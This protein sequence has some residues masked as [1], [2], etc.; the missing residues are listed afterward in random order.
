MSHVLRTVFLLF[1]LFFGMEAGAAAAPPWKLI[2][3]DAAAED[4]FGFSVDISGDTAI[5]GAP[6]DDD[7]G[8]DSGSA[9]VFRWN[10]SDWQ[11]EDKL[12]AHD[13]AAGDQFGATVAVDGD[14]AIVG[15]KFDDSS[16]GAAYVFVRSGSSW[17]LQQKLVAD[18]AA[19]GDLL[20]HDV[21]VDGD[22]AIVG[23]TSGDGNAPNS[24]SAY[25]FT[26]SGSVWTQQEEL[27]APDGGGGDDFGSSVAIDGDSA[28]VGAYLD[29][30][31]GSFSGSAYVFTRS[32][33]TWSFEQILVPL[34][35]AAGDLFGSA[36]DIEADTALISAMRDEDTAGTDQGSAY[37]F[38]RSGS[39]WLQDTK[40]LASDAV[41][42]QWFGRSA[43]LNEGVAVVGAY[44][45]D[46]DTGA[47]YVFVD[48]GSDWVEQLKIVAPDAAAGDLAG[49]IN[50]VAKSA[51]LLIVGAQRD[52]DD[53]TWSGSA[54]IFNNIPPTEH[55]LFMVLSNGNQSPPNNVPLGMP[56]TYS[57]QIDNLGGL[58]PP[59]PAGSD[60][61]V[62]TRFMIMVNGQSRPANG[63]AFSS[64]TCIVDP[65]D[66]EL[67][68]CPDLAMGASQVVDFTWLD[69]D[70]S[71]SDSGPD[72]GVRD[73]EFWGSW[74]FLAPNQAIGGESEPVLLGFE[75]FI[76]YETFQEFH[77]DL[78]FSGTFDAAA[79][80][81]T[82]GAVWAGDPALDTL[83][84]DSLGKLTG[85][86]VELETIGNLGISVS[87]DRTA[88]DYSAHVPVR[89]TLDLPE[90]GTVAAEEK[91]TV[92]TNWS[93]PNW[94]GGMTSGAWFTASRPNA[95]NIKFGLKSEM[96]FDLITTGCW[97]GDCDIGYLDVGDWFALEDGGTLQ[98]S[99][100]F[101]QLILGEGP[102]WAEP[103]M[104][105]VF[106]SGTVP[107][108]IE[109]FF[110]GS[111]IDIFV[112]GLIPD[113]LT[114]DV[115]RTIKGDFAGLSSIGFGT[116]FTNV[117]SVEKYSLTGLNKGQ[118]VSN[119][120]S[121]NAIDLTLDLSNIYP[122][123]MSFLCPCP[124]PL[125]NGTLADLAAIALAKTDPTGTRSKVL[126]TLYWIG[127]GLE[128]T[129]IEA[130]L[131][132]RFDAANRFQLTPRAPEI[133]LVNG[134]TAL[135]GWFRAGDDV[136]V[137]MPANPDNVSLEVRATPSFSSSLMVLSRDTE[138]N[139]QAWRLDLP[140]LPP[141]GPAAEI[142]SIIE[143]AVALSAD[144]QYADVETL[145]F[146]RRVAFPAPL[147]TPRS[148]VSGGGGLAFGAN[149]CWEPDDLPPGVESG[150]SFNSVDGCLVS[151][152]E[153][154]ANGEVALS[155]HGD[156]EISLTLQNSTLS[157]QGEMLAELVL[158]PNGDTSVQLKGETLQSG[159]NQVDFF[160]NDAISTG[161]HNRIIVDTFN[162]AF[163][164]N[165]ELRGLVSN[166]NQ[167][168]VIL[169]NGR[170]WIDATDME[171]DNLTVNNGEMTIQDST[172]ILRNL[173]VGG[174][175]D[176]AMRLT[177]DSLITTSSNVSFNSSNLEVG[178][179][180]LVNVSGLLNNLGVINLE[181][182]GW[183]TVL[184]GNDPLYPDRLGSSLESPGEVNIFGLDG[185]AEAYTALA[186]VP[187]PD[188]GPVPLFTDHVEG[189]RL[190]TGVLLL[191]N[192]EIEN[193]VIN[194]AG[195]AFLGLGGSIVDT[196]FNFSDQATA[197]FARE[198]VTLTQSTIAGTG[199]I[200]VET[201]GT[202][203][204]EEAVI[205]D[206]IN[207]PASL[208]LYNRG[209]LMV[210]NQADVI[211]NAR[212]VNEGTLEVSSAQQL[213][214]TQLG[215]NGGLLLVDGTLMMENPIEILSGEMDG[216][217][218]VQGD[219]IN[220]NGV[221]VANGLNITGGYSQRFGASF[222]LDFSTTPDPEIGV[223]EATLDGLLQLVL[224]DSYL[225]A[226]FLGA[227]YEFLTYTSRAGEFSDIVLMK[228]DGTLITD[229]SAEVIYD[230]N[231][232]TVSWA[233]DPPPE[234]TGP[235]PEVYGIFRNGFE[236]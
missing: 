179:G 166:E 149:N 48:A 201:T 146:S 165:S 218:S 25:V 2:A 92:S 160:F 59:L 71:F 145:E 70:P 6:F 208:F 121:E 189:S 35:G 233:Y 178:A 229:Y 52:S 216:T 93:T 65:V 133:R 101:L 37:I 88:V 175:A 118:S 54:H 131:K 135:T 95:V 137:E 227:S 180:S 156:T 215:H 107:K 97:A 15:A 154:T 85:F 29:G 235:A 223:D 225:Q 84:L 39:T 4:R 122:I 151:T 236:E 77:S 78:D 62:E 171:L 185:V 58:I 106:N 170:L 188:I 176:S 143:N 186:L 34:D 103:Y 104:Q 10:G 112:N 150:I 136:I 73:V 50:G 113:P 125:A 168:D 74:N 46:S 69:P 155:S 203:I 49:D 153:F 202:L 221:I 138:I 116:D 60:G 119:G 196:T 195:G 126:N 147:T 169:E 68:K 161:N 53:G 86:K 234:A 75:T 194:S 114:V 24:G 117:D 120:W 21:A 224:P 129:I 199:Q 174:S 23:A 7:G 83:G 228:T 19:V 40:L 115:L 232:A 205:G 67:W 167:S 82:V 123:A 98:Q 193:H 212:I 134:E 8:M 109:Q 231:A 26:R 163:I 11:E 96:D 32:G 152:R 81:G 157:G 198:P 66:P 20:G 79:T 63:G 5:V 226:P 206:L 181:L 159:L 1:C 87:V 64:S 127:D 191:G 172:A 99:F 200:E 130:E 190:N 18:D 197:V 148:T 128:Y 94:D 28:I 177:R 204:L 27:I 56:V 173:Q 80:E 44:R 89:V 14:T 207:E 90:D 9:Y 164:R 36:V 57:L 38:T 183:L 76:G 102:V 31:S 132:G 111:G 213:V 211:G 45:D 108:S 217:G 222:K 55:L 30:Y 13:A 182:G 51:D 144:T 3:S 16:T 43:S 220:R 12:T 61:T 41:S 140:L 162:G 100:N 47:A 219:V 158:N 124:M 187:G 141:I 209:S 105:D 42:G 214:V 142:K 230:T 192:G 210:Q 139:M 72:A 110:A 22:T 17:T 33:T 184:R 91:F